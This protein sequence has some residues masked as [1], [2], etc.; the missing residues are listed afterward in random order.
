[1]G[2]L[3]GTLASV[4]LSSHRWEDL[5]TIQGSIRRRM[6]RGKHR[7]ERRESRWKR[8]GRIPRKMGVKKQMVARENRNRVERLERREKPQI[9]ERLERERSLKLRER[10]MMKAGWRRE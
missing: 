4:L 10:V 7:R 8:V 6:G 3:N 9:M 5:R 1:M 2:S